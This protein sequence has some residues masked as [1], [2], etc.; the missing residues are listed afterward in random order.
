[1]SKTDGVVQVQRM[2]RQFSRVLSIRDARRLSA[3]VDALGGQ[4][5][6]VFAGSAADFVRRPNGRCESPYLDPWIAQVDSAGFRHLVVE[7]PFTDSSSAPSH[8][9]PDY[10]ASAWMTRFVGGRRPKASKFP[11]RQ[12]SSSGDQGLQL[13]RAQRVRSAFWARFLDH[14]PTVALLGIGLDPSIVQVCRVRGVPTIEFQHGIIYADGTTVNSYWPSDR[15]GK[16]LAPDLVCTWNDGFTEIVRSAGI[17]AIT[18]G[19]PLPTLPPMA[20]AAPSLDVV[21][22]LQWGLADAVDGYGMVES[23]VDASIRVAQDSGFSVGVRV[24]PVAESRIGRRTLLS[25]FEDR[26]PGSAIVF[27]SDEPITDTLSRTRCHLTYESA[28]VVEAMLHGVPSIVFGDLER[29]GVASGLRSPDLLVAGDLTVVGR[30]L[31][32][33]VKSRHS[34]DVAG[35]SV[36]LSTVLDQVGHEGECR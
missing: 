36:S 6:L 11:R 22:T 31:R 1:M 19:Y 9:G 30:Q 29:M 17:N 25:V 35:V 7:H 20:Q 12:R 24:H 16:R 10:V 2:L 34:R 15:S 13:T 14:V 23:R 18:V 27:P 28:T 4:K 5:C 32:H 8:N 21:A 3:S 33:A 26:Y